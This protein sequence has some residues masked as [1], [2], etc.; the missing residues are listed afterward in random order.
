[1]TVPQHSALAH[2]IAQTILTG[3]DRHFRIFRSIT[4]RAQDHFEQAQ[5]QAAQ[6][7]SAER[8]HYYDQRVEDAITRLRSAFHISVLEPELWQTVK[9]EYTHLLQ[10]HLQ[11]ELAETFFNSLFCRLF[12]RYYYNNDYIY[13]WPSTSSSHLEGP[14]P[15]YRSYF[16]QRDGL[17]AT[18]RNILSNAGFRLPWEDQQR[19]LRSLFRQ[20]R[21]E[22]PRRAAR[23]LNLRLVVL[24]P[25]LYRNKAAYVIGRLVNGYTETPIVLAILNNE[26]G[27]L[28][29]D[30]IL[31]GERAL[32]QV[33]SFA[34]AYFMVDT[35]V[36]SAVVNFVHK[37][38]PSKDRADL[39]SAIG[40]HKQGKNE[41]Y[42]DFLYHLAYTDDQFLKAPGIEGMVMLVFTLPSYPY[43]FK[44]IRDRFK[45]PKD[46]NRAA[47]RAKYRLV[48]Q[49]DRVGRMADTMEFSRAAFPLE[50]FA[51]ELLD[52]LRNEASENVQIDSGELVINHLY[53]ERRM[54]PLNLF[55]ETASD[56]ELDAAIDEYGE[57]I[58]DMA[59]AN[60]F[61]G[62]MLFKNFGLTRQGRVVFYDYDEIA[63]L[64]D[65]HFRK[66]PAPRTPEDE[67]A[68]EPWY[69]VGPNDVFPEEFDHFLLGNP[70]VRQCFMRRHAELLDAHWWQ[71]Q[72]QHIRAGGL[73]DV[74]P[75]P[76]RQ[77]LPR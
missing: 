27:A 34:R 9:A 32:T 4:G 29:V 48:K 30:A 55:M 75:Y 42:R 72:Q 36:P 21:N 2:Q 73:P 1:M 8:I 46:T 43:V 66:I 51:P 53:I 20:L 77:R 54:V 60:I 57:A 7:D 28:Y 69:S 76:Q 10:T 24:Q 41:F 5:W 47:V 13:V 45:P 67:F 14:K 64:T 35:L 61:P 37:M 15:S 25:I 16:P 31:V 62:D 22:H 70:R 50:R 71:E 65:C 52:A 19:D 3:F 58:R 59:A 68:A 38:L 39:Y 56:S 17:R 40:F 11:P 23:E 18:V 63:Y 26:R 12:H 6:E 74:F 44:V 49:H 33:F